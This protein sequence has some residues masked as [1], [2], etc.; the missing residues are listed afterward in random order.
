MQ[1]ARNRRTRVAF[2][3]QIVRSDVHSLQIEDKKKTYAEDAISGSKEARMLE[4]NAGLKPIT[5]RADALLWLI[6]AG[7]IGL[8]FLDLGGCMTLGDR[9]PPPAAADSASLPVQ[10]VPPLRTVNASE[11]SVNVSAPAIVQPAKLAP[12]G[13]KPQ[14]ERR[15]AE[16]AH[17]K[18]SPID[19]G[20]LI[21][22]AP[23]AVRQLLG[24]PARV[25]YSDL[26]REWIYASGGCSF[27][28]FFY[29]NL[30]TASFRVLKYGGNHG[31]GDLMD[32]SDV[33]IRH[34]LM[35]KKNATG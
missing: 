10:S 26:S 24:P 23:G 12:R 27:R 31:N 34:I 30:N 21:G 19:P 28:V 15:T 25:E 2:S 33:C 9:A 8:I 29:P 7:G 13:K 6:R 18:T 16:V 32:V 20:H 11:T 3:R 5:S 17:Q 4:W 22:L 35:A 14:R 1:Q